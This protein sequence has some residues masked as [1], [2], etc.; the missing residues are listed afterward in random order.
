MSQ[1]EIHVPVPVTLDGQTEPTPEP[2]TFR[3]TFSR[4]KVCLLVRGEG[5]VGKTSLAC[6]LARWALSEVPEERLMKHLALP[7]LLEDEDELKAR[8][9]TDFVQGGLQAQAGIPDK[10]PDSLLQ[11]LLRKRRILVIV[12]HFSEM[13]EGARS[14]VHPMDPNFPINALVLTSRHDETLGGTSITHAEPL[15]LEG[16]RVSTFMEA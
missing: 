6:Q 14:K 5:G 16:N 15:R 11:A 4:D 1:R 7:V 8:P 9:F 3:A 12:D 2:R 13:S 10:V